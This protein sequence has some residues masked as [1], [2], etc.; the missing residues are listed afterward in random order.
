MLIISRSQEVAVDL[1]HYL[2]GSI[3]T[4]TSHDLTVNA[5]LGAVV[6]GASGLLWSDLRAISF[7]PEGAR[8]VGVRVAPLQA[9]L[10]VLLSI[11]VVLALQTVGLLMNIALLIVP[12]ATARLWATT[13]TQ[14]A[15]LG[16]VLGI[17]SAVG[18]LTISYYAGA[19]PGAVIALVAIAILVVSFL[20]TLPRRVRA[21]AGHATG[22]RDEA[23][24][25]RGARDG[26]RDEWLAHAMRTLVAAGGRVGSARLAVLESLARESRCMIAPQTLI[27]EVR[28]RGGGS[29][30][31]VYRALDEFERLRLIRRVTTP[32]GVARIE[33]E[34]PGRA[35]HHLLDEQTG[36]VV[37]FEDPQL[38]AAIRAAAARIGA[39]V[40]HAELVL[41]GSVVARHGGSAG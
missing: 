22:Q 3:T 19:A 11:T 10:L 35:H 34:R 27:D 1:S 17:A 20:L 32:D 39:R 15:L 13:T 37:A 33:V 36:A 9:G 25:R 29:A 16:A 41:L 31:S 21:V 14:I 18:G 5:V 7:D 24:R 40:T 2:F 23:D 30:S 12:A 4:V 6:L 26:A 38:D 8:L 28:R